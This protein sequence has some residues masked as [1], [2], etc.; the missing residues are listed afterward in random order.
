MVKTALPDALTPKTVDA[1]YADG[2]LRPLEQLNLSDHQRVSLHILPPN[3][4]IPAIVARRKVSAF[5]CSEISYLM[6]GDTPELVRGE[7][8]VWRV[9][10]TLTFPGH[11][12]V[13]LVGAIDVDAETGDMLITSSLIK[14]IT[15]NAE[16]LAA[17]LPSEAEPES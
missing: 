3:V 6:G 17:R 4:R 13:G 8:T 10:V 5:A 12:S 9:P 7:Q 15:H 2:V 14:E 16:T 11:G 1:V